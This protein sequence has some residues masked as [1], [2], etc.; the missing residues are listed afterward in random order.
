VQTDANTSPSN[1]GGP[2][3]DVEGK[4]LGIVA[5]LSSSGEDA[6]A[7]MYDSGIG[8][9]TTIAGIEPL[10]ERMKE[11]EVLQRGWLGVQT[12]IDDLGP[13]ALLADVAKKSSAEG[14][15]LQKGDRI[16]EVDGVAVRNNFHLQML[17]GSKLAGDPV[18][19]KVERK[20]SAEPIGMTVFLGG[21][22]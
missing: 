13:G 5:P 12:K 6:G 11:G 8:F 17:I 14:A 1:Y 21:P 16:L 22:T 10:L 20:G 7:E 3:V 2:L 9:A 18:H 4:V 19:V 15:G